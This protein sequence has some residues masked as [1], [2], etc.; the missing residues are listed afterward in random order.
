MLIIP[1]KLQKKKKK[2]IKQLNRYAKLETWGIDQKKKKS[3]CIY[4]A[5]KSIIIELEKQNLFMI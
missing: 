4:I 3:V 2:I 5:P 1:Q